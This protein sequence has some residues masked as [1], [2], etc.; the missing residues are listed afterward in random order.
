MS[1]RLHE[2]AASPDK[3]IRIVEG[4]YHADLYQGGDRNADAMRTSFEY[5]A[6]WLKARTP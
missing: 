4:A 3:T 1:R 5:V 6:E 2:I